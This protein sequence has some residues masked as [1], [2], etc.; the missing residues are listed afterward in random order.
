MMEKGQEKFQTSLKIPLYIILL[1][2]HEE[3]PSARAQVHA[4][5]SNVRCY[6]MPVSTNEPKKKNFEQV[7]G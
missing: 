3:N 5:E 7:N 1:G 2:D 6:F 4:H